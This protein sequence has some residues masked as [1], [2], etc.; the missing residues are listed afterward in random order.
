MT[1]LLVVVLVADAAQNAMANEYHSI[2]EGFVLILTIASWDYVLDWLA[3]QSKWMH[4][5]LQMQPLL[6]IRD[7]EL[8]RQNMRR[9]MISEED[10]LAQLRESGVERPELVKRCYLEDN[11]HVSVIR[12]RYEAKR[13]KHSL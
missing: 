11:G 2:T 3:Y 1:D 7:G 8:Q 12:Y 10:L 5:I 6:L 13:R 4:R 9:E